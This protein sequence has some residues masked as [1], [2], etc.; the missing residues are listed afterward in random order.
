M[1]DP[2]LLLGGFAGLTGLGL[3]ALL[4]QS[5]HEREK[6]WRARVE[7]ALAPYQPRPQAFLAV[8][9]RLHR[10]S[11]R[12]LSWQKIAR[13]FGLQLE[14][15]DEYPVKWWLVLAI[16]LLLARVAAAV[17]GE[18]AG[19]PSLLF[20]PVLWVFLSRQ[21]FGWFDDRRRDALLRQFPDA[22][23]MIVRSV[24]VGIP[25]S[26]AIRLV[27]RESAEPTRT[28]FSRMADKIAIGLP[29][30]DVLRQ[31]AARTAIQEYR[32]FATALMLQS[33]T[34]GGLAETLENLAD[35]IRRRTAMRERG[36]ALA[37]EAK[38]SAGILA[39]LPV[40]AGLGIGLLNPGYMGLL[41]SDPAG[42]RILG[43]AAAM[44]A[45]GI[46][47]MRGLIRRSLS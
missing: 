9:F 11:S 22:L 27:A 45:F 25:V 3:S 12:S 37:S 20:V 28:E 13:L 39:A 18:L 33:Q 2:R 24:R 7:A 43:V 35:V 46:M 36:H 38:T 16:T 15:R 44:L 6:A 5:A 42:N 32:F 10:P 26:E 23:A 29:L 34:G 30:E 1:I 41:F 14:R 17:I 31:M 21:A 19:L 47:I 40:L 4:L 8:P